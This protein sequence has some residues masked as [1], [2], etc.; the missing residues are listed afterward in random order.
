MAASGHSRRFHR[1][2]LTSGLTQQ[3]DIIAD[4]RH[5]CV[6]FG[7]DNSLARAVRGQSEP[8]VLSVTSAPRMTIVAAAHV[9]WRVPSDAHHSA[10]MHASVD[11]EQGRMGPP[12][13]KLG[14][15]SYDNMLREPIQRLRQGY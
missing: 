2:Q 4:F 3:A 1:A 10:T 9:H 5:V 8:T 6:S 11:H 14:T 12:S 7:E 13:G 15:I